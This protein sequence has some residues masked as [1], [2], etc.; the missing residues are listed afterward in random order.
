[1]SSD[2]HDNEDLYLHGGDEDIDG[3]DPDVELLDEVKSTRQDGLLLSQL[4]AAQNKL[5]RANARIL[6]FK[7]QADKE[8]MAKRYTV[9][10]LGTTK[11]TLEESKTNNKKI[12][13]RTR[14]L[15]KTL[16]YI[17]ISAMTVLV[18]VVAALMSRI[19]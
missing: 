15:E 3:I 12:L 9:L 2:L 14:E 1:M 16:L 6:K 19:F 4:A 10:E 8:E 5:I 13:L 7:H 17:K 18:A 11:A